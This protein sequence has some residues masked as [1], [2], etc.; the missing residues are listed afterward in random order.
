MA[1]T[2]MAARTDSLGF[3][4]ARSSAGIG[5][6]GLIGLIGI[7]SLLANTQRIVAKKHLRADVPV[8]DSCAE[9]PAR[10]I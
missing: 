7:G 10:S 3:C 5:L 9:R 1:R 4:R 2:A 8:S 6:I